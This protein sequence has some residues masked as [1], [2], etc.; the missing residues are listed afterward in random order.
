VIPSLDAYEDGPTTYLRSRGFRKETIRRWNIR[1]ADEVTLF[2]EDGNSFTLTNAVCIPIVAEDGETVLSW[3]YR[4][5]HDSDSWFRKMRYI[6]TPQTTDV[7]SQNWFGMNLHGDEPQVTICE[8]ALDAIWNDQWGFPALAILG[9]NVKQ[10][11]KIRKLTRYRSVNL[12]TDRDA[13][14]VMTAFHLGESLM[15]LGVPCTVSRY[16]TYAGGKDSQ[17]LCGIDLELAHARSIPFL[18]WKNGRERH[19]VAF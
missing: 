2:K 4:A 18:A 8:G 1:F 9:S 3:C 14:G 11:V 16:P 5:T 6:Y 7:L 12:M 10:D 19:A 13:S 17:D 15:A